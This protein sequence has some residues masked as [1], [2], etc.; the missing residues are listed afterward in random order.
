MDTREDGEHVEE[1][2]NIAPALSRKRLRKEAETGDC[3]RQGRQESR[4]ECTNAGLIADRGSFTPAPAPPW[5][6][7]SQ[8]GP[9]RRTTRGGQGHLILMERIIPQ[10]EVIRAI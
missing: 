6:Q 10:S 4:S 1:W 8:F 7:P 2:I 5:T 9:E 3:G